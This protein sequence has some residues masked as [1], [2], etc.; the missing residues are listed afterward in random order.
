MAHFWLP[1]ERTT[2][3]KFAGQGLAFFGVAI[4]IIWRGGGGEASLLDDLLAL[5]S[6]FCWAGGIALVAR[7]GLKDVAPDRLLVWQVF[8]SAPTLLVAAPFF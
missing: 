1:G 2:P 6:A 7:I 8:V 4:A 3:V 5:L